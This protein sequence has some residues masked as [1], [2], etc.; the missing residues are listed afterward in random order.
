ME[1]QSNMSELYAALAVAQGDFPAIA[2][3][4]SVS[5]TSKRTGHAFTFRYADLEQVLTCTRKALKENGLSIVNLM[6]ITGSDARLT[7]QL[8]HK[9]GGSLTSEVS[10]PHPH[11]IQDPKE[12]GATVSYFRRYL[13]QA[14]L[15]VAA[16][17]DIDENG[18]DMTQQRPAAAKPA[19][20]Q[21][22][23]REA[24]K[25]THAPAAAPQEPA[26]EKPARTAPA[27]EWDASPASS[28]EVAYITRKV[29]ATGKTLAQAY[30]DAGLTLN[31]D[32]NMCKSEFLTLRGALL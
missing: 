14:M 15:N 16:D 29:Q 26:A 12:F 18:E 13:V 23:R 19:V 17:D 20:A 30:S 9:S 6:T 2:K 24:A 5:I 27:G 21:P 28:G 3:N 31:A 32:A 1:N 25:Q 7:C 22:V 10:I 4:R 8:F 11:S